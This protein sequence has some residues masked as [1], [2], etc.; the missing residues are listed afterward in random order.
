MRPAPPKALDFPSA[1]PETPGDPGRSRPLVEHLR[2]DTREAPV[3]RRLSV[4]EALAIRLPDKEEEEGNRYPPIPEEESVPLTFFDAGEAGAVY[5]QYPCLFGVAPPGYAQP[6]QRTFSAQVA[7]GSAYGYGARTPQP[8]GARRRPSV[9]PPSSARS[10]SD[11]HGFALNPRGSFG[12]HAMSG[13]ESTYGEMDF[14][15]RLLMAKENVV[16][17]IADLWVV[18]AMN[19]DNE[20]PFVSDDEE[21]TGAQACSSGMMKVALLMCKALVKRALEW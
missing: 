6:R 17:N 4:T 11:G 14:A 13:G 5:W 3:W 15:Q 18:A 9:R 21:E 12:G 1:T 20:D 10:S 16:M 8:H 19:V 7:R 2:W